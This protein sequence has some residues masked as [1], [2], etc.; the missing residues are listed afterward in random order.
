MNVHNLN[1]KKPDNQDGYKSLMLL[2]EISRGE[3][4]SQRDLSKRLNL[5]LG[6]VNS[7]IKNLIS[8][9][10]VTIKNIPSKRYAYFLTAKGFTEKSRL[11]YHLLQNYNRVFREARRDFRQLFIKL[12]D[13]GVKRVVFA[14][15]DEVAEIAYL[16]L[17]ECNLNFL[18]VLDDEGKG[19]K[20][21]KTVVMPFGNVNEVDFD[22]IIITTHMRR[23]S[24][25]QKLL[26]LGVDKELIKSI[27][28][29]NK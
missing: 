16:S 4:L 2:D 15:A 13:S 17:Q 5:A 24:V 18:G 23:D 9:G 11:T 8:K 7:Y 1:D 26:A 14:G 6:L 3:S 27:Y 10:F 19:R 25:Y 12:Q 20:F 21:F 22:Y 28:P 29:V